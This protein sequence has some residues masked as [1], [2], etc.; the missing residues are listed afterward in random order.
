MFHIIYV[1]TIT[2]LVGVI[3][4]LHLNR[5]SSSIVLFG[6]PKFTK[7]KDGSFFKVPHDLFPDIYLN[8]WKFKSGLDTKTCNFIRRRADEVNDWGVYSKFGNKLPS[9]DIS[10]DK[11]NLP[12]DVA[13]QLETFVRNLAKFISNKFLVKLLDL[14]N[15]EKIV[16]GKSSPK[17]RDE[18]YDKFLILKG[19]P[20]VIKYEGAATGGIGIHKDNADVSFILL[21]SDPDDFQ[22]GGTFFQALNRT[23]YLKQGEALI[24]SGQMVH[25][26]NPVKKGQRYVISGFITIS[27]DYYKMKRL[28]TMSTIVR[29]M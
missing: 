22:G 12:T 11:L 28:A 25:G 3:I 10:L 15:Q 13:V 1:S 7:T 21:L 9:K 17:L 26:A 5:T 18:D 6:E 8:I 23:V 2:L 14:D 16:N 29:L 20:F 27:E 19:T 24:F 4:H